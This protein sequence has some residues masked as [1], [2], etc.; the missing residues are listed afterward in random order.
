VLA[1]SNWH[2]DEQQSPLFVLPSSHCSPAS[3][4]ESPQTPA[5]APL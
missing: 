1:D 3:I 5:A 4:V 2:V